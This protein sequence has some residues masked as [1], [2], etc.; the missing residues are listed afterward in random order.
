MDRITHAMRREYWARTIKACNTSGMKKKDWLVENNVNEKSFYRWQKILRSEEGCKLILD[1]AV[2][3]AVSGTEQTLPVNLPKVEDKQ[4]E[5]GVLAPPAESKPTESA[6]V[7]RS[8]RLE[9]EITEDIS[10]SFLLRI[11]RAMSHD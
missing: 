10:D 5:F 3:T 4:A 6:A 9:V 11:I 1:G 7:L 2:Q 8:G